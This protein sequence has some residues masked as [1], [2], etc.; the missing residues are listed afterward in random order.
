MDKLTTYR[1]AVK[2]SKEGKNHLAY[3]ETL[4]EQ[5]VWEIPDGTPEEKQDEEMMKAMFRELDEHKK[6]CEGCTLGRLEEYKE[7]LR[8]MGWK[9]R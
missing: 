9:G 1:Y 2:L 4:K 5:E 7:K 6:T 3:V 8:G